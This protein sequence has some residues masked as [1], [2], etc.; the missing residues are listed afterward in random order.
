MHRRNALWQLWDATNQ[1]VVA[2]GSLSDCQVAGFL[3]KQAED[4][5]ELE[6]A[7]LVVR[8]ACGARRHPAGQHLGQRQKP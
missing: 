1:Q 8:P 3:L 4:F 6:P 7:R 5:A 2:A